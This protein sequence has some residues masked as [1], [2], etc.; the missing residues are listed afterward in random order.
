MARKSSSDT[1]G[2]VF[3]TGLFAILAGIAFWVFNKFGG[4]KTDP[5]S[6]STSPV[7]QTESV[8]KTT[9]TVPDQ[10]LPSSTT[11][12]IVR[13]IYYT[14]SYSE[15][16]EQA[17]WVVYELTKERLDKN[18]VERESSFRPDPEVHTESATPND[19]RGSGYDRG[20][21]APAAD[22]AF[23]P[24]AMSETFFM[25]NM[26]PQLRAFNGGIWRE[27]EE[28]TRDWARHFGHLYVVTGPVLTRRA[29]G[30][31]GFSKVT[32]PPGFYKVL[33]APDQGRA[34]A[35][36]LPNEVSD[37]P[38]MEYALTID[39]VE[40]LTGIDFFP[41]LLKGPNEELEA[42]LDKNAWPVDNKRYAKRLQ[43]WNNS[44]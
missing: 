33:L 36:M 17:E 1:G 43:S 18:W 34:I 26:S 29:I 5:Y 32:V 21:L 23:N 20:H 8:E 35:F 44:R 4:E 2:I 38:L 28:N 10:I 14:L 9:P 41:Q 39:Q 15:E 30:Q 16:H 24:T 6:A 11:G 3:K 7:E 40:Q 13:H 25:S 31:I 27:L 42:S 19:Y 22:M 37:K 12:D